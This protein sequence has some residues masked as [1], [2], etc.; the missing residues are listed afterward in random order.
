MLIMKDDRYILYRFSYFKH[1]SRFDNSFL[2]SQRFELLD[3]YETVLM[4]A[5][6]V[7]RSHPLCCQMN[8]VSSLIWNQ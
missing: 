8:S 2:Y 6:F 4:K 5:L 7:V 1:I 3:R